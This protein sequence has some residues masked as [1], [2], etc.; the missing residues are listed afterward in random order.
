MTLLARLVVLASG[1]W[2]IVL[3]ALIV[4]VPARAAKFLAGFANSARAHYTE[5]GLRLIVGTAIIV[6][7][8]EMRFADVFRVFGWILVL[9]AI[10]LVLMPWRWHRRFAQ[11]AIPLAVRRIKLLACGALVLG[12]LIFYSAW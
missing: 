4:V 11:W 2:L 10:G 12:V 1:L 6:F 8:P 5:Q 9:T 7:A 3:A